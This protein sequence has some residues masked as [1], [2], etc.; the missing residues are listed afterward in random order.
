MKSRTS[1][2]FFLLSRAL[3]AANNLRADINKVENTLHTLG[4]KDKESFKLLDAMS[5]SANLVHSI[6]NDEHTALCEHIDSCIDGC[7]SDVR[8][9]SDADSFIDDADEPLDQSRLH[10]EFVPG[11]WYR[12]QRR[13]DRVFLR[14]TSRDNYP[15]PYITGAV[16]NHDK[17]LF[18][19][20]RVRIN[21]NRRWLGEPTEYVKVSL[22]GA[23][24]PD[25]VASSFDWVS[26]EEVFGDQ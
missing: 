8:F 10:R 17:D 25:T 21:Q 12:I 2:N 1:S 13:G 6:I 9:D 16:R 22:D 11:H 15:T 20:V 7:A 5:A 23:H 24:E 3:I 26:R 18:V 14:V 19:K 4:Y